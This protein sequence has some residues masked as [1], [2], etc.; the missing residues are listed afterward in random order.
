MTPRLS[1]CK[2]DCLRCAVVKSVDLA[3]T[4][5]RF[6]FSLSHCVKIAACLTAETSVRQ[7]RGLENVISDA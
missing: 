5:F 7:M 4:I 6:N 3:A 1:Q 2:G